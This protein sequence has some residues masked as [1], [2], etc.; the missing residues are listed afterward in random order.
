[1]VTKFYETIKN[2]M[3]LTNED[4]NSTSYI[5]KMENIYGELKNITSTSEVNLMEDYLNE[6][7][8][9]KKI[10]SIIFLYIIIKN[11]VKYSL[12]QRKL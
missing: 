5:T 4:E 8:K 2:L 7:E 9:T 3:K 10:S 11:E 1:M 6:T 12:I